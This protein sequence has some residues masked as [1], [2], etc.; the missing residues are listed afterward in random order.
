MKIGFDAK[1]AFSN[2]SGLGNYSRTVL[3]GL[4][5]YF[6][7][8]EYL[9]YTPSTRG[10]LFQKDFD[11]L[12][13][14][15][16]K[17]PKDA[18][19]KLFSSY[20]R[21]LNLVKSLEKDKIDIFHGLSNEL[22]SKI[23]KTS[24]KTVV[25]IHDLIFLRFP[26]FFPKIDKYIYK[27][28]FKH[29]CKS[30]DYIIAVSEQ[31]KEDIINFFKVKP[32]KVHVIY[33]S[34]DTKFWEKCSDM[35]K[36]QIQKKY[37]LQIPFFLNVGTIE[38]R[39]NVR[40]LLYA[41]L[42]T[43]N[44]INLVII[45]KPT[46]YIKELKKIINEKKLHDRITFYHD[47]PNQDLPAFYQLAEG[48]VYPSFFEGFGIPILEALASGIPVISSY[49]SCLKETGGNAALYFNPNSPDE[50]AYCMDKILEDHQLKK[51][52]I[53]KGYLHAKKFDK[54]KATENLEEIYKSMI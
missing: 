11:S 24:I 30:A 38:P 5:E 45:G 4:Q 37:N 6:P 41:L 13:N 39:K 42:Y 29:A 8:N 31:T 50:I 2:K 23:Q 16:I 51:N 14:F 33:Q 21:T 18:I 36:V 35:D 1:R 25:T 17:Q 9:L 34:C 40:N 52:M 53:E 19:N 32:S 20:W 12:D 27:N 7:E 46:Y 28:K 49:S 22:P 48:C 3:K 10:D 44:D 15:Q 54:K 47:V 26:E 43:R